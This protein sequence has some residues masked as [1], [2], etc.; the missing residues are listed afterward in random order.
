MQD[1]ERA[2]GGHQPPVSMA[3]RNDARLPEKTR[4]HIKQMADKLGY[5][6]DPMLSAL[7]FYRAARHPVKAP[8]TIAFI[9]NLRDAREL[10]SSQASVYAHQRFL[11]GAQRTAK[12]LGY[13]IE[14]FFVHE[15]ADGRRLERI[16]HTRGIIGVILCA[17]SDRTIQFDWNWSAF[18]VTLIES[19]NLRL[20]FHSISSNQLTIT[21]E[22]V[23]RL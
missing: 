8:P 23:Q 9:L 11:L 5:Q 17:M 21:R 19:Q 13:N 16:L 15:P 10:N 2:A 7:N 22:A 4:A 3:L 12:Q 20:S 1:V 18:C 14:V 6:P